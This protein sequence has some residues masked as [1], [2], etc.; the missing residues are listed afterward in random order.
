MPN[1]Q[2][3]HVNPHGDFDRVM[4]LGASG[5]E[6]PGSSLDIDP[7]HTLTTSYSD[8]DRGLTTSDAGTLALLGLGLLILGLLRRRKA[9]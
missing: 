6:S 9:A 3:Y 2:I 1:Q 7:S 4:L 5:Q 8:P